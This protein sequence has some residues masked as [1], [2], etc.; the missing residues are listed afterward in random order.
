[1]ANMQEVEL[2]TGVDFGGYFRKDGEELSSSEVF[3]MFESFLN[4]GNSGFEFGDHHWDAADVLFEVDPVMYATTFSDWTDFEELLDDAPF[5]CNECED[6][7]TEDEDAANGHLCDD[8]FD[9][10]VD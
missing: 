9:N 2:I 10:L 6:A 1:M 7:I 8:C 3:E 5:K 4:E